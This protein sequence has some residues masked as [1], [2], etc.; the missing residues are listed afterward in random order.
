VFI[1]TTVRLH[2]AEVGKFIEE[3]VTDP[4]VVAVGEI[5]LDYFYEQSPREEQK[6]AFRAQ[7]EIAKKQACPYRFILGMLMRTR[8]KY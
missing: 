6:K 8:L 5:G 7:L 2:T 3:H 4:V 1:H